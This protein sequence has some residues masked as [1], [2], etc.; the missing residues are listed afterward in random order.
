[1]TIEPCLMCFG[2]AIHARIARVLFGAEDPRVGAASLIARLQAAPG[3]LNHRLEITG[4]VRA[5]ECS[6]ILR[7]FFGARR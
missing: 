4:G 3:A 1:V 2:A 5:E 6:S 7:A